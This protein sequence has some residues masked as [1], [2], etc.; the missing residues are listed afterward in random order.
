MT[1][2]RLDIFLTSSA[3]LASGL[4]VM[5]TLSEESPRDLRRDTRVVDHQ[6]DVQV[7]GAAAR[8]LGHASQQAWGDVGAAQVPNLRHG[9]KSHLFCSLEV[10]RR[11]DGH[12][13]ASTASVPRRTQRARAFVCAVDARAHGTTAAARVKSRELVDSVAE[14]GNGQALQSLEREWQGGEELAP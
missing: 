2:D 4:G 10:G 3:Y 11:R 13:H 7:Q 9:P 1:P 12:H 5:F 6:V 8:Q 14:D